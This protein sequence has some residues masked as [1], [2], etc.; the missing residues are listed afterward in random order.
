MLKKQLSI[1]YFIILVLA[2]SIR[3]HAQHITGSGTSGDPYILYNAADF[4]S[5]RYIGSYYK[6]YY[7]FGNDIDFVAWGN[8]TPIDSV[9]HMIDGDG[10][11]LKNLEITTTTAQL[12]TAIF[13]Y[14]RTLSTSNDTIRNIVFAHN[15]VKVDNFNG[16]FSLDQEVRV[17][18]VVG[19]MAYLR[20]INCIFY[21]NTIIIY[22]RQ[23][24]VAGNDVDKIYAGLAYA[25]EAQNGKLQQCSAIE[26]KIYV[27][28][29]I[30]DAMSI[31]IFMGYRGGATAFYLANKKNSIYIKNWKTSVNST[32]Y[33]GGIEGRSG[34]AGGAFFYAY[35]DTIRVV[36]PS[37]TYY[38]GGLSGNI[39]KGGIIGNNPQFY[40][41]WSRSIILLD[42][43]YADTYNKSHPL[44]GNYSLI[45]FSNL[46]ADTSF[47]TEYY[48]L[49]YPAI[50]AVYTDSIN[51]RDST[52]L[53]D[54]NFTSNWDMDQTGSWGYF[55]IFQTGMP[56]I[57]TPIDIIPANIDLLYPNGGETFN[58]PDTVNIT[59]TTNTD[60]HY[61]YYSVN[62]GL[63]WTFLDT[64]FV[65][66][67]LTSAGSY[68]WNLPDTT[69][70]EARV[71]IE[72][73]SIAV[74]S[75]LS[76][77][78]IVG[79]GATIDILS[80]I[81]SGETIIATIESNYVDTLFV[82]DGVDTLSMS[83]VASGIVDP[84]DGTY[85]DT[86][87]FSWNISDIPTTARM[88][89]KATTNNSLNITSADYSDSSRNSGRS[90]YHTSAQAPIFHTNIFKSG[91][92]Y[93]RISWKAELWGWYDYA[94]RIGVWKFNKTTLVWDKVSEVY[95]DGVFYPKLDGYRASEGFVITNK[96]T[97]TPRYFISPTTTV[98]QDFGS[99]QEGT[100]PT[101]IDQSNSTAAYGSW[102]YTAS[103][104]DVIATDIFTGASFTFITDSRI[105]PIELAIIDNDWLMITRNVITG[106][107]GEPFSNIYPLLRNSIAPAYDIFTLDL[108]GSRTRNYFRGVYPNAIINYYPPVR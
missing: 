53:T 99:I 72:R 80:A 55:P 91:S 79:S 74:D 93:Y 64:V 49:S 31:G 96:S 46:Y 90:G 23:T 102:I 43:L 71:K 78:Y 106:Q 2:I 32:S 70:V 95:T 101:R 42:S 14:G 36:A 77:F 97:T 61:V 69:T 39:T 15:L 38:V 33:I 48:P 21:K 27:N 82:Y 24:S 7:K 66:T 29:R 11:Q 51:M 8:F 65:D 100:F 10:F 40:D 94:D 63:S 37:T 98:A 26:N 75:S 59:F 1:L 16:T 84:G 89:I 13:K 105:Y 22:G 17:A 83:F 108:V 67:S 68:S 9:P 88:F 54:F 103:D 52:F 6:T 57:E 85:P 86:T 76:T 28:G 45:D 25:Y 30:D 20:I 19:N 12:Y 107:G 41:S 62:D 5:I 104:N 87:I 92:D 60:T 58:Y 3:L 81:I 73:D 34:A 50:T 18:L 47:Y 56:T 4:D 44:Y 35:E